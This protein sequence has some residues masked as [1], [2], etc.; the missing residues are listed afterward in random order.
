MVGTGVG[1]RGTIPVPRPIP[2]QDPYLTVFL[3]WPYGQMK[4]ILRFYEVS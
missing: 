3:R 4:A 2:S 1:W